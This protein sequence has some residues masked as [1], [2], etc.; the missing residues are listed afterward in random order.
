VLGFRWKD[1]SSTVYSKRR[2]YITNVIRQMLFSIPHYYGELA[3]LRTAH[4]FVSWAYFKWPFFSPLAAFPPHVGVEV[5]NACNFAC[6]HCWRSKM[7]RRIG[8]IDVELFSQILAEVSQYKSIT[9]KIGGGGEVALHPRFRDLMA[10]L[11]RFQSIRVYVYTNGSLL[12]RFSH[13]EILEWNIST[14]VVSVDGTDPSSY[15]YIRL[16]GNYSLLRK[17][18]EGLYALR[19]SLTQK[20]PKIEI[21]HVIMPYETTG[22]L[23]DVR[24]SWLRTADTVKFNYLIPLEKSRNIQR[25]SSLCRETMRE[26]DIEWDGRVRLCRFYP[27]YFGDLHSSTIEAIWHSPKWKFVRDCQKHGDLDQIPACIGCL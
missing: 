17:Q 18:V 7:D 9:L 14:L 23:V 11:T 1:A 10:A 22:Q 5:T 15:N 2:A 16:G 20:V 25:R 12:R 21:R 13:R 4:D 24:K 3:E 19:N 6:R 27:E 8:F 26:F